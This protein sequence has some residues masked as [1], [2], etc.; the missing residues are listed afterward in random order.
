MIAFSE[1]TIPDTTIAAVQYRNGSDPNFQRQLSG[2][3][4]NSNITLKRGMTVNLELYTWC[5]NVELN[6]ALNQ[7]KNI[8]I[9]LLDEVGSGAVTPTTIIAQ[10]NIVEAWPTKYEAG[11]LNALSNEVVV[12]TLELVHEGIIRVK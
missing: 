8:S 12:E 6:G 2:L 5:R 10:W 7:R 11:G 1:V 4:N 9:S 3:N